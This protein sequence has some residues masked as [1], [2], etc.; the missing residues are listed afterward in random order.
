MITLG[1]LENLLY[2]PGSFTLQN[3]RLPAILAL[4]YHHFL[5]QRAAL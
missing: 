4:L 3:L 1:H 2:Q 5:K